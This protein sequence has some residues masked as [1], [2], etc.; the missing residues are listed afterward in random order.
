MSSI[1][2]ND[3]SAGCSLRRGLHRVSRVSPLGDE[4]PC[5]RMRADGTQSVWYTRLKTG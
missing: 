3:S 4:A 2:G 1:G 5:I